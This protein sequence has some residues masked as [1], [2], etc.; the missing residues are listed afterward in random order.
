[1]WSIRQE[2]HIRGL[3][4]S[5]R[6]KHGI[7]H[8]QSKCSMHLSWLQFPRFLYSRG[9]G[10]IES[11]SLFIIRFL[12]CRKTALMHRNGK[13]SGRRHIP[14]GQS[15]PRLLGM[16]SRPVNTRRSPG[17]PGSRWAEVDTKERGWWRC[18]ETGCLRSPEPSSASLCSCILH[19]VFPR[20]LL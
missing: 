20:I 10:E 9:P 1:M 7:L 5:W 12:S 16:A 11:T 19:T 6:P 2:A 4:T 3:E 8:C 15:G 18:G 14:Y 17:G 13:S